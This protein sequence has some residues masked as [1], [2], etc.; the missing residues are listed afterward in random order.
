MLTRLSTG[1]DIREV[2]DHFPD[3]NLSPEYK[4]RIIN[5]LSNGDQVIFI[6]ERYNCWEVAVKETAG[7]HTL[8]L[9]VSDTV[10]RERL[11][12][13]IKDGYNFEQLKKRFR[14]EEQEIKELIAIYRLS[15]NVSNPV[16]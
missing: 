15:R 7:A 1:A 9:P 11:I 6:N 5:D 8:T 3:R 10:V 16:H 12:Q 4:L 14:N 2:P 13:A